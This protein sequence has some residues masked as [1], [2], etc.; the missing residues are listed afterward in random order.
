[1]SLLSNCLKSFHFT[2]PR[3]WNYDKDSR[4]PDQFPVDWYAQVQIQFQTKSLLFKY[5][6]SLDNIIINS[7]DITTEVQVINILEFPLETKISHPYIITRTSPAPVLLP[8]EFAQQW[9]FF[10]KQLHRYTCLFHSMLPICVLFR[11]GRWWCL[12][13]FIGRRVSR[14]VRFSIACRSNVVHLWTILLEL[15]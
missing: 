11:C 4:N 7:V 10:T 15:L 14:R 6:Y 13:K 1:M 5:V 9:K 8:V 12:Q 3:V 2:G